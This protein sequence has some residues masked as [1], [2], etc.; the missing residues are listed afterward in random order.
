MSIY[1]IMSRKFSEK[2]Y[3]KKSYGIVVNTYFQNLNFSILI[4]L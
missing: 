3:A 1:F 2:Y 4:K